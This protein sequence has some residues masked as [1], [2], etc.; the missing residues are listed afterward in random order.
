MTPESIGPGLLF[1]VLFVVL[2]L[3]TV[4]LLRSL[5]RQLRKVP[6]AFDERDDERD[7]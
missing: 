2:A 1:S 7:R 3:A 5:N 6:P 4:L